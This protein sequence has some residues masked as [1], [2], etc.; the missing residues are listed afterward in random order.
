MKKR[1]KK[2]NVIKK[3]AEFAKKHN[4][5]TLAET[6][7]LNKEYW[8]LSGFKPLTD[9]FNPDW[10]RPAAIEQEKNGGVY[11]KAPF[12]SRD[13]RIFWETQLKRI[14]EGYKT[15]GYF[16]PGDLYFF[17]NFYVLPKAKIN[18]NDSDET[19]SRE[20]GHPDFWDAHYYFSH[21]VEWGRKLG[22]DGVCVKPR[23][24]GWS[25]FVANMGV[26]KYTGF[27]N[28]V[29]LY[30]ASDEK[31]LTTDGI[32]TKA[33]RQ[34]EYLNDNTQRGFKKLRQVRN[35]PLHKRASKRDK[36]GNETGWM[37]EI[38]GII[39]DSPKKI[40]GTR[41]DLLVMEEGGSFKNSKKAVMTAKALTEIG[42][43]KIGYLIIF[44][45]GGDES[46]NGKALEGLIKMFY[47]PEVFGM[48]PL[49]NR[50]NEARE[51]RTTGFFFGTYEAQQRFMNYQGITDLSKS[52]P[53]ELKKRKDYEEAG[54]VKELQ[55][56]KA[57]YPFFPEEAFSKNGTSIFNKIKLSNTKI[58]IK[59]GQVALKPERGELEWTYKPKTNIINGVRWVKKP[60]G[61]IQI[62]EHPRRDN[63]GK[64]YKNLYIS[65]IDSIDYGVD[66]S[67]IGEGGS[68]FAIVIK[69]KFLHAEE[70]NNI[71]VAIYK[72][73]PKDERHAY[74]VALK[75]LIYYNA[76][77]NLERTRK[78]II[79]YFRQKKML[80]FFSK[81]P[82][83]LFND[84]N[85][86]KYNNNIGTP[87]NE[88]VIHHYLVNIKEYIDDYSDF[89]LFED[90][91]EE[92]LNYSYE[93]KKKFDYVAA[94]GMC[95][96]LDEDVDAEGL[97]P[98]SSESPTDGLSAWG[99]YYDEKGIKRFGKLPENKEEDIYAKFEIEKSEFESTFG[100]PEKQESYNPLRVVNPQEEPIFGQNEN[101]Q[102]F[103]LS[104]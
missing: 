19:V 83:I 80:R 53:H 30:A 16:C 69:K 101:A 65:G 8:S 22:K 73:R 60:D 40:R 3:N 7:E 44:G 81:Q 57:E 24:V 78:E 37:S 43:V 4:I 50:Y 88:R 66:N 95:E 32:L 31:Y 39:A 55:D 12:G 46:S 96:L 75:L 85:A 23:G 25:E 90:L 93:L 77:A 20:M 47:R 2:E 29:S 13:Y 1:K 67:L 62:L 56:Y 72:E 100:N 59:S 68:K 54:A 104:I 9:K 97:N 87:I 52:Y 61:R 74:E 99:Y 17:L 45:T 63:F 33:W 58:R 41:T 18:E 71:Y 49:K 51:I 84:V 86:K 42:G 76:K 11:T 15:H 79:S 38:I 14:R 5:P 27:K 36:E 28:S 6:F 89:I 21:Y 102:L 98:K 82:S 10:F 26:A 94:M 64:V 92:L 91:L 103:E 35:V 70:L 34:L 48:L